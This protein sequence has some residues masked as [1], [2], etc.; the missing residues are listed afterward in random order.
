MRERKQ[1]GSLETRKKK[2]KK[3]N[4]IKKEEEEE[5]ERDAILPRCENDIAI[6]IG[7]AFPTLS[8]QSLHLVFLFSSL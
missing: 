8:V 4:I 6:N 7:S 2:K 1:E 5:G 3:R